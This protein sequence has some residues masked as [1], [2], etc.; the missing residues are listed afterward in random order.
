MAQ[1]YLDTSFVSACISDREDAASVYRRQLSREWWDFQ[2]PLH[3]VFVSAEVITELS[4]PK[5]PHSGA[6]LQFI[7]SIPILAYSDEVEGLAT[8]MIEEKLMPGPVS[9]DAVHVA[10]TCF[11]EL[12]YLLTWNV[13]HL[14]NP[15]KLSHLRVLC[16]RLGLMPPQI[17]TPDLLW[18]VED[19]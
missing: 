4:V 13:R 17:I 10:I 6:A 15:N 18:E 5:Y 3:D 9:G 2:R 7:D 11:H 12:D 1:V 19:V 16:L 14:A 8:I